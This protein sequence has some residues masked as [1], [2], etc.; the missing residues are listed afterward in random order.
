MTRG[1]FRRESSLFYLGGLS[2]GHFVRQRTSGFL[3]RRFD[4]QKFLKV[5]LRR[6]DRK[7]K[8]PT[9]CQSGVEGARNYQ[10][11]LKDRK[12][13]NRAAGLWQSEGEEIGTP[14]VPFHVTHANPTRTGGG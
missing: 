14:D 7:K 4:G 8:R 1:G 2:S 6:A 13:N 10:I 3:Y 9:K 11:P 12:R 5:C